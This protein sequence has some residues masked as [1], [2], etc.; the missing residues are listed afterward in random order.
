MPN[1]VRSFNSQS[2]GIPDGPSPSSPAH[3]CV[4][5]RQY[6]VVMD[7]S[8]DS[9][10][11]VCNNRRHPRFLK[12]GAPACELFEHRLLTTEEVA[13]MFRVDATAVR[14]WAERYQDTGGQEGLPAIRVG[15]RLLRFTRETVLEYFNRT[16]R[17]PA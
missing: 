16:R 2:K 4:D 13:D 7:P 10:S 8:G 11:P 1:R 15:S 9:Q 12:I 17:M 6:G 5:C 3:F 14:R